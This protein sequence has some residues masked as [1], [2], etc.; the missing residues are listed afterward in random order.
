M[1]GKAGKC[2]SAIFEN[3]RLEYRIQEKG[4]FVNTTLRT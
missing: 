1:A 3:S 4:N 2:S